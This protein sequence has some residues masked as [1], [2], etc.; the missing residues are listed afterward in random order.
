M[1]KVKLMEYMD[2]ITEALNNITIYHTIWL[3]ALMLVCTFFIIK[4]IDRLNK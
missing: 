4:K 3:S 2:I 1:E